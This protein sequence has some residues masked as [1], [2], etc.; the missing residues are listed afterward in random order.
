MTHRHTAD[1]ITDEAL[2]HLY[3]DRDQARQRAADAYGQ[4][5]RLRHRIAALAERWQLPGH[6]SM[7]DA[8]AEIADA[9]D[10]EKWAPVPDQLARVRALRDQWL[11]TTLEPGQVRRLLDQLTHAIDGEQP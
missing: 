6:I 9:L 1:T 10:R 3:T 2:D 5:D 11:L 7:P 8:A 4:R